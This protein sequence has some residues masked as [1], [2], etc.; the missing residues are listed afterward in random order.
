MAGGGISRKVLSNSV[1]LKLCKSHKKPSQFHVR[2]RELQEGQLLPS[3]P[4]CCHLGEQSLRPTCLAFTF[5]ISRS[6]CH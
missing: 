2:H 4:C 3:A 5:D 1:I 6:A